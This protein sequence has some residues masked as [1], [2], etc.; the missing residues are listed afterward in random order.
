MMTTDTHF[1]KAL[2]SIQ[3]DYHLMLATLFIM[4]VGQFM[5][6]PFLAIYLARNAHLTPA[7]IGLIIGIGP[8]IYGITGFAAGV[9]VDRFGVKKVMT[10]SLFLGGMTI[11]LFFSSRSLVWY[12]LMNA[13]TGLTRSFFDV[14]SKSYGIAGFSIELRRICF[15]LRFMV[16]N[17]A[18]AIG[19]VIGAYFAS[20]NSL[21]SF[22]LI[23]V[24]YFILG[25][26]AVFILNDTHNTSNTLNKPATFRELG[27]I[28]L[29]DNKLKLLL[30]ISFIF[31]CIYAQ[32]DSTLPQYLHAKLANGVRIYSL[33]LIINAVGCA[34][35]QLIVT[36]LTKDLD[37]RW[38]SGVA[39]I[40]LAA[41]YGMI[42][43]FLY[44]SALILASILI[45]I[46]ETSIMPLNDLLLARIAPVDR[47]GTYYGIVSVAML[48]LGVGPM[49]GGI[50]YEYLNSKV[51]FLICS[52]LSLATIF[53]YRRLIQMN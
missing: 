38:V 30:L 24:L 9:W 45:V 26:L 13:L 23:G 21:V 1:L 3:M 4:K 10:T 33:L 17:S 6:L 34:T 48:G 44:P 25:I 47:I 11:Y 15:S 2:R 40:L 31:W 53:L 52:F 49:L 29:T 5:L 27:T 41:A 35:T 43:F 19:P 36:Q 16:I 46:A 7:V 22:K 12:F 8:V 37:E 42:A 20:T 14:G 50:I 28:L 39:L 18:A 32:L 51:I